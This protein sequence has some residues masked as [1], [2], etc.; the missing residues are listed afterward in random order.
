[1]G[2]CTMNG[3]S[4]LLL[5][6]KQASLYNSSLYSA[7]HSGIKNSNPQLKLS[8]C[9]IKLAAPLDQSMYVCVYCV[10]KKPVQQV[11]IKINRK[12]FWRAL[13]S[14]AEVPMVKTWS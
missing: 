12:I 7:T 3:T 2:F 14:S 10:A 11:C 1:M 8:T 9:T 13:Q 5:Q 6:V 4:A